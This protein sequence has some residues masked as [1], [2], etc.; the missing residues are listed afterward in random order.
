MLAA[1]FCSFVPWNAIAIACS[2]IKNYMCQYYFSHCALG[3][4]RFSHLKSMLLCAFVAWHSCEQSSLNVYN[5]LIMRHIFMLAQYFFFF[6]LKSQSPFFRSLGWKKV[7]LSPNI[8]DNP[9]THP[10]MLITDCLDKG[11]PYKCL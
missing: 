9:K 3:V 7:M 10:H 6:Q 2:W 11:R 4:I 5:R 8:L 1:F